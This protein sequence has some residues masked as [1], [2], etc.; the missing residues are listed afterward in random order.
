MNNIAYRNITQILHGKPAAPLSLLPPVWQKI[1]NQDFIE[2]ARLFRYH[3]TSLCLEALGAI[4]RDLLPSAYPDLDARLTNAS[5]E[6]ERRTALCLKG[7]FSEFGRNVPAAFYNAL[8]GA[9]EEDNETVGR[10]LFKNKKLQM[11]DRLWDAVLHAVLLV[12][13][14]ALY[15]HSVFSQH[16]LRFTHMMNCSCKVEIKED[17]PPFT[18][19]LDATLKPAYLQNLVAAALEQYGVNASTSGKTRGF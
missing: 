10:R 3:D 11:Q 15:V 19:R 18:V 14:I 7:L 2:A 17:E 1:K 8:L 5:S 13:P 12:T 4:G 6:I 16:G 9:L